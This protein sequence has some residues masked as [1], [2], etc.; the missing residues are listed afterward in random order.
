MADCRSRP[1]IVAIDGPAGSG[2]GTVAVALAR[3]LGF[4]YIET[5]SFFRTL[6]WRA[7]D[8]RCALQDGLG[9]AAIVESVWFRQERHKVPIQALREERIGLAASEIG[10]ISEVRAAFTI[11]QRQEVLQLRVPGVVIEGRDI[12]TAL[13]PDADCKIF[14]TAS[15]EARAKRRFLEL[16]TK[17]REIAYAKVLEDLSQ[18]DQNDKER[19]LSPLCPDT[20]YQIL[21]TSKL[22]IEEATQAAE[23]IVRKCLTD[24]RGRK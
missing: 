21:D 18:R 1:L 20:T 9:L 17:E 5:G 24:L 19:V 16:Q 13:F 3:C 22:S 12:G 6:A 14:L 11:F 8:I 7:L 15:V 23:R 10:K 4:S 2:K